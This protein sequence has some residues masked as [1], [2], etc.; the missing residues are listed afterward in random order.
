MIDG[1]NP[2]P[3]PVPP[4]APPH[5]PP[6][7]EAP[8]SQPESQEKPPE[9]KESVDFGNP[10]DEERPLLTW[11]SPERL[12]KPRGKEFYTTIAA[13][14]FLLSIITVF[15]KEFLLM[16]TI[17]AFAFVAFAMSRVEP[18]LVEHS[19]TTRGIKTGKN[20]YRWGELMRF[21]FEEK[22]GHVLLHADT[23]LGFPRRITVLLGDM[24]KEKVKEV[25]VKRIP[26][27]KPEDT[28]V[29]K[30]TKWLQEKVP[31]E[32]TE[33]KKQETMSKTSSQSY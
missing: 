27:D 10:L 19:L 16:L 22:W 33:S 14:V 8:K 13:F 20:K 4:S 3:T 32:E 30:A 26:Y 28:F 29:D 18:S 7:F 2:F 17:W 9:K 6:I 11:K 15:F 12:H 25:L 5:A 1:V 21:W 23:F 24:Q 31:L